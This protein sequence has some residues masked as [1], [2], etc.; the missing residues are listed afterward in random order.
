MYSGNTTL[1]VIDPASYS[2]LSEV[3][4]IRHL[5]QQSSAQET[6]STTRPSPCVIDMGGCGLLLLLLSLILLLLHF[7]TSS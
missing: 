7:P 4:R 6:V 2:L 5:L 1:P 3:L